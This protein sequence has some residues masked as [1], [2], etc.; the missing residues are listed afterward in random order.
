MASM[1]SAIPT[2][3]L[4]CIRCSRSTI[5]PCTVMTPLRAFSG[6]S[7]AAMIVVQSLLADQFGLPYPPV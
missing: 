5:L 3:R 1:A 4:A 6:C 2:V 7:K